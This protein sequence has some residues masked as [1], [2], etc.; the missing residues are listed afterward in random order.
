MK[1]IFGFLI[2]MSSVLSAQKQTPTVNNLR[3]KDGVSISQLK[4]IFSQLKNLPTHSNV[5]MALLKNDT[6]FFYGVYKE[7]NELVSISNKNTV[8]EIGS[9]TKV[10]TSNL[11]AQFVID[12]KIQRLN[13]PVNKYYKRPFANHGEISFLSL[14]NH[15]SGL[16][17]LPSNLK[18]NKVNPLNP[19]KNY[20]QT[21]F[22]EYLYSK[23]RFEY[24]PGSTS[25][26]SHFGT[27]LLGIS[28]CKI[29]QQPYESIL[30]ENILKPLEMTNTSTRREKV[31]EKLVQGLN[32]KGLP[33]PNWDLNIFIPAG[34]ML[35]SVN[36]LAKFAQSQF[37]N[38]TES[39]SLTHEITYKTEENVAIGLGWLYYLKNERPI[40]FQNGTSGGYQ[41]TMA[42]DKESKKGVIILANCSLVNT[43]EKAIFDDLA[44][45][46]LDSL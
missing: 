12:R 29:A 24:N 5:S 9:L 40:L 15:T 13:D 39:T 43:K 34:G 45:E 20:D 37:L 14:A 38:P 2:F 25:W 4:T 6:V 11:L 41:S 35:S 44:F 46:L 32:A 31:K 23:M 8:Y 36:D 16:P 18:L 28:L 42:I 7:E 1:Y 26:Y 3:L 10:F 33:T 21:A 27:A 30:Q 19:F 17:A 22:Y